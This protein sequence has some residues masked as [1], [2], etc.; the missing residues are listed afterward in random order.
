MYLDHKKAKVVGICSSIILSSLIMISLCG[1]KDIDQEKVMWKFQARI[2][3]IEKPPP[4]QKVLVVK[5]IRR[6][7][8]AKKEKQRKIYVLVT[9]DTI[10]G[11]E[12]SIMKFE[13]LYLDM[14]IEI[15]GL[16]VIE[17]QDGEEDTF[18]HAKRIRPILE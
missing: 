18:V 14:G 5:Q 13:D 15:Q 17:K 8:A 16:K 10:I 4:D 1:F 3:D 11:F 12:G 7:Q 2:I 9:S 6:T